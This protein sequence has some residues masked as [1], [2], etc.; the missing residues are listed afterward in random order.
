M[1]PL[2][3]SVPL[4]GVAPITS[5]D[6]VPFV[7]QVGVYQHLSSLGAIY[8]FL[9]LNLYPETAG[10]GRDGYSVTEFSLTATALLL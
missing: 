3:V 4:D 7:S 8:I 6:N 10:I 9:K 5:I 2:Y 1:Y